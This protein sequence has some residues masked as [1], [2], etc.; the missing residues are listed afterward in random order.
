MPL[1]SVV[2]PTHNRPEMLADALARIR[3]QTFADYEVIVVSNREDAARRNAC[4][5]TAMGFGAR[6]CYRPAMRRP[7]ATTPS[8]RRRDRLR[9]RFASSTRDGRQ[10][11]R[12]RKRATSASGWRVASSRPAVPMDGELLLPYVEQ[13]LVPTLKPNDITVVDNLASHKVPGVADTIEAAGAMLRYPPQHSH[14]LP[15]QFNI[16]GAD[17]PRRRSCHGSVPLAFQCACTR[18]LQALT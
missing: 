18:T 4:L 8:R 5:A 2:V 9:G 7:P 16:R 12:A 3:R 14:A 6:F 10:D 13:H 15:H 1:V 17:L 11:Q